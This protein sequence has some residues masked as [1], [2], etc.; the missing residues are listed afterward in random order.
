MVEMIEI[1]DRTRSDLFKAVRADLSNHGED[2]FDV[3]LVAGDG[4]RLKISGRLLGTWSPVM[5]PLHNAYIG[6]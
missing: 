4:E 2:S 3:T 1:S 6:K 5:R